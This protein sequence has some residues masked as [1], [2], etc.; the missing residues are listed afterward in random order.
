MTAAEL[1]DDDKTKA[2]RQITTKSRPVRNTH[3]IPSYN[4]RHL[5]NRCPRPCSAGDKQNV[6]PDFSC[7]DQKKRSDMYDTIDIT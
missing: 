1:I 7:T 6:V 3:D 2:R 4:A 5:S